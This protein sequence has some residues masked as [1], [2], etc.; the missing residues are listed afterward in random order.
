VV[1]A[2]ILLSDPVMKWTT[3]QGTG[4]IAMLSN[5]MGG[6][7]ASP[8]ASTVKQSE[9]SATTGVAEYTV[10][11][12]S[13]SGEK[14]VPEVG[15]PLPPF[16]VTQPDGSTIKVPDDF[17]GKQVVFVD[18]WGTWCP[19]CVAEMPEI[20]KLQEKYKKD[21]QIIGIAVRSQEKD[22]NRKAAKLAVNYM[23]PIGDDIAD[24]YGVTAFPTAVFVNRDG[25]ITDMVV[26]EQTSDQFEEM[27]KKAVSGGATKQEVNWNIFYIFLGLHVIVIAIILI[28]RATKKKD[29]LEEAA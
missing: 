24:A 11:K 21:L 27:Y 23:L 14:Q 26:G 7:E 15:K 22:I 13:V 5:A 12:A 25:I 4:G 9:E 10:G 17:K 3:G 29:N 2:V 28:R 6:A 19:S 1:M 8:E 18:F 20:V 16:T